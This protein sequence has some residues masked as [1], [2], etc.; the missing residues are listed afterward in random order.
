MLS[1]PDFSANGE[2]IVSATITNTGK[3]EGMET[4]QLYIHD[5][6]SS[7]PRP[8]RELKGFEKVK[9]EVGESKRV[10]FIIKS[11]D[12]SFYDVATK[13]WKAEPGEFE[14]QIGSSSHDMKL[15]ASFRYK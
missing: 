2:L 1:A 14:A 15:I 11:A 5:K 13:S 3:M 6:K 8:V 12:L 9:L 4:V 10:T 7:V